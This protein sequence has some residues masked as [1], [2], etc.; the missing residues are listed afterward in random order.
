M[1]QKT[2]GEKAS[3]DL[4]ALINREGYEIG[5]QL[6]NE[7]ALSEE[8]GVSRNTV[9]EAIRMLASRNIVT[10]RQGAGTFISEK[11]GLVDDPLGFSL[12]HDQ[13]KLVEDLMQVRSIIEPTIAGLAAEYATED[14]LEELERL[15]N[16]IEALIHEGKD[17]STQDRDF[18]AQLAQCSGNLVMINLIPVICQGVTTFSE[19]VKTQEYEQTIKSHRRII[20]AVKRGRVNDAH[21]A[22]TYHLLHNIE[23]FRDEIETD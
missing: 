6:P 8:L 10:I 3:V 15:G 12:M 17:F 9:R 21:Q 5:D 23:R 4:M 7:Y 18:H 19:N 13:R 11:R 14:Q 2:L 16:E 20:E 22:M 1:K